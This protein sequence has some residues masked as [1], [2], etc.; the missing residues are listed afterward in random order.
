MAAITRPFPPKLAVMAGGTRPTRR[1]P[2]PRHRHVN[3]PLHPDDTRA[4]IGVCLEREC[5]PGCE[6]EGGGPRRVFC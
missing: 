2:P 4:N 6:G 5:W 1:N 3:T